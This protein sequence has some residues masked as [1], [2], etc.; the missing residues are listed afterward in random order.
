MR[1]PRPVDLIVFAAVIVLVIL[2]RYLGWVRTA[3]VE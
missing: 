2:G 3:V 1:R